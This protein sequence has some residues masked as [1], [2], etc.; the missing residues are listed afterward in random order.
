MGEVEEEKPMMREFRIGE[1]L[2]DSPYDRLT[3]SEPMQGLA[4]RF[5]L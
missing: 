5:V 1:N 2:R 4:T 3:L